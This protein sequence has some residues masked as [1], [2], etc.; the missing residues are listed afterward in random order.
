MISKEIEL[1]GGSA[2]HKR[3]FVPVESVAVNIPIEDETGFVIV[4]YKPDEHRCDDGVAIWEMKYTRR[5]RKYN[6]LV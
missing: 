1:R 2:D 4:T 3:I 6:D 5:W